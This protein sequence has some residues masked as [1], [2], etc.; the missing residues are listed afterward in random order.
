MHEQSIVE[1]LLT[2]A[3]RNAEQAQAER[4]IGINV[5][6]GDLSG[7]VEDAVNYYFSFLARDTIAAGAVI[8]YTRIPVKMRCRKCRTVFEPERLDLHCPECDGQDVDIIAGRE[9]HLESL[10][11]V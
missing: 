11:I 5:V 9:L 2:L 7:V 10:E 1:S 4:I 3:L 8:N 6:V